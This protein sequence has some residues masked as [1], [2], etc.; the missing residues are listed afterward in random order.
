MDNRSDDTGMTNLS[1]EVR[2][3]PQ[4]LCVV[5]PVLRDFSNILVV[6]FFCQILICGYSFDVTPQ[7]MA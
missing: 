6:I 3:L 2:P 5:K 1:F 4:R 7:K